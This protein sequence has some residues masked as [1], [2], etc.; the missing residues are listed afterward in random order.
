MKTI[1]GA[2]TDGGIE[3]FCLAFGNLTRATGRASASRAS[4]RAPAPC[5][6]S[7]ASC[8]PT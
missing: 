8:T 3:L 5:S 1:E 4:S 7:T 2:L 6:S